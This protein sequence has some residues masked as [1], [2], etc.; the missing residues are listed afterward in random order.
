MRALEEPADAIHVF[1]QLAEERPIGRL[2]EE[3]GRRVVLAQG[4]RAVEEAVRHQ[5]G[6]ARQEL[7]VGHQLGVLQRAAPAQAVI[8]LVQAAFFA[9]EVRGRGGRFGVLAQVRP[10]QVE[11]CAGLGV[12]RLA[13]GDVH[14]AQLRHTQRR[15][16]TG[17]RQSVRPAP[18]RDR[19]FPGRAEQLVLQPA[20][21][22]RHAFVFGVRRILK[23][24][25]ERQQVVA[26]LFP[27][28]A[29]QAGRPAG[30]RLIHEDRAD[31]LAELL[32]VSLAIAFVRQ[33]DELLHRLG[34]EHV[35]EVPP[36]FVMRHLGLDADEDAVRAVGQRGFQ[37]RRRPAGEV[38]LLVVARQAGLAIGVHDEERA[39][40]VGQIR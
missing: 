5:V 6:D 10:Q 16:L 27:E 37:D 33:T 40:V 13:A 3:G 14:V 15:L 26:V 32:P 20:Q 12:P 23:G 8:A 4:V 18:G 9:V 24:R 25:Q 35:G 21:I 11:R 17:I 34:V 22:I 30:L 7:T 29:G 2:E 28:R 38:A 31:A 39:D 19:L 1:G 36:I